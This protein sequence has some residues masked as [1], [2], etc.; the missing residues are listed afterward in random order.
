[1]IT[2]VSEDIKK[3]VQ[4]SNL[5]K[6]EG[7]TI[8]ISGAAGFLGSYFIAVFQHLNSSV[9][10]KPCK[11]FAIDNF[12]T[13]SKNNLLVPIKDRNILFKN[14]DI[15]KGMGRFKNE[16]IDYIIHAAG[17][18]SPIYYRKYPVASI[19]CT[20]LGLHHLMQYAY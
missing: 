10:K 1:M 20:V 17:L 15:S 6:L 11:V 12:I 19:N 3:I 8:F 7:K 9:F 18:A 14:L 5:S 2:V 13:G 4:F 16:K